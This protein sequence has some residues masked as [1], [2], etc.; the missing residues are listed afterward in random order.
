MITCKIDKHGM[1]LEV[2]KS[3]W[4]GLW[5]IRYADNKMIFAGPYRTKREAVEKLEEIE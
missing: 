2:H 5:V 4:S 3:A 1:T